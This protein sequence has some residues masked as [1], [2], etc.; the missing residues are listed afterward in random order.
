[1]QNSDLVTTRPFTPIE[2]LIHPPSVGAITI[3]NHRRHYSVNFLF[4]GAA[5][6]NGPGALY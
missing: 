4:Y 5:A 2:S 3:I 1:M 6:Y